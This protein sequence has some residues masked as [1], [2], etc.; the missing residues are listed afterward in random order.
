M[1]LPVLRCMSLAACLMAGVFAPLP[2]AA[3]EAKQVEKTALE[4]S[5]TPDFA[6][7][8][9]PDAFRLFQQERDRVFEQPC[10]FGAPLLGAMERAEPDNA[11][12]ARLGLM[13]QSFCADKEER[14]E[15][16]ADLIKSLNALDPAQP[17]L[18]LS[19]YFARRTDD[20]DWTLELLGSL[21]GES[22]AELNRDNLWPAFR[23]IRKAGREEDVDALS[24]QWIESGKLAFLDSDLWSGLARGA[25]GAAARQG[26]IEL[27]D[28]LLGYIS[29][30]MSYID[31]LT[32]RTYE[33]L[34]PQIEARAGA[35]L[36]AVGAANVAET[37]NRLT[38]APSDRDRFSAAAHALHYNG[39]FAEAVA[40]A[41]RWR[42]R[43]ERGIEI[44]EGDGWAL[45]IEAYASDSLGQTERADAVFDELAALDPEEHPWVVNFVINRGSRLIGYG[46]WEEGLEAAALARTVAEDY[47]STYAKLIIAKDH[48]CALAALGRAD[49]AADELVFLR[50]NR[51]E[52]AHL[53]AQGLL[54]HGLRVE[55]AALLAEA[56]GDSATRSAAIEALQREEADLFYTKS[57]LPPPRAL[58]EEFPELA[59]A[60]AQQARDLPEEFIPRAALLRADLDLPEWEPR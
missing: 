16:G 48:A 39:D 54:C 33:Q 2:L 5:D 4:T 36:E 31:L 12:V 26:R 44:E 28:Q 9:G 23:I 34:W 35:N 27:A 10:E 19:L 13:I 40:L 59:A 58:M 45:N 56:L 49:E 37:R 7:M 11:P 22:L 50:E 24:L 29:D 43:K 55:A 57:I 1:P 15:D 8:D 18:R 25:L 38:L 53:A 60:Y 46:R 32:N 41:Q 47:G 17:E 6:T 42:E 3:Q 30:P 14:Y 52:S 21:Q 51:V 20:V